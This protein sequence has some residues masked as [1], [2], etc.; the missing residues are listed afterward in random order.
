M[1]S[2]RSPAG[3]ASAMP[4]NASKSFVM[5]FSNSGSDVDSLPG[6]DVAETH[7]VVDEEQSRGIPRWNERNGFA[8]E[9]EHGH[10]RKV[11]N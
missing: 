4:R 10:D 2:G 9:R 8:V 5:F 6:G 3:S 7:L 11:P 1:I